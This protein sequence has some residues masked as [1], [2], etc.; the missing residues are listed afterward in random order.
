V[1]ERNL[2]TSLPV[3]RGN[4]VWG[5]DRDII[6]ES[7]AL[8]FLLHWQ[9]EAI[10]AGTA[11][12]AEHGS[13]QITSVLVVTGSVNAQATLRPGFPQQT[14]MYFAFAVKRLFSVAREVPKYLTLVHKLPSLFRGL[15]QALPSSTRPL[16]LRVLFIHSLQ[17]IQAFG[18][19]SVLP[20]APV[21]NWSSLFSNRMSDV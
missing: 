13:S 11:T 4:E 14:K 8:F 2:A 21:R 9:V 1:A 3:L 7:L 17:L 6:L 5:S 16:L 15:S 10:E 18:L 20:L 19:P 12:C